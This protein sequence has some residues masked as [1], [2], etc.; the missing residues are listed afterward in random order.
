MKHDIGTKA[1]KDVSLSKMLLNADFIPQDVG[2]AGQELIACQVSNR[3]Q[4]ISNK[5][6]IIWTHTS[7]FLVYRLRLFMVQPPSI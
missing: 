4:V 7:T 2:K 3:V 5:G 6:E 1:G